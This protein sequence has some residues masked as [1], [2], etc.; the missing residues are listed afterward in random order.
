LK[1]TNGDE[2][3]RGYGIVNNLGY[4]THSMWKCKK[5]LIFFF[6]ADIPYGTLNSLLT[7]IIYSMA[8]ALITEGD[9]LKF[10][11]TIIGMK[12]MSMLLD[13]IY[14]IINREISLGG[15]YLNQYFIEKVN[16]KTMRVSYEYFES[17]EGQDKRHLAM[18]NINYEDVIYN[19]SGAR[20]FVETF[21]GLISSIVGL[22]TMSVIRT[23]TT[24]KPRNAYRRRRRQIL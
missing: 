11:T 24:G 10:A 2:K 21:K 7:N 17:R 9:P 13:F 19:D 14:P 8:I 22:V 16:R 3:K 4:L 1:K 5:S 15:F 12:L 18:S 23:Y 20:R 6:L